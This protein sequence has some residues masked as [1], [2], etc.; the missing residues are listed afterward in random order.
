MGET[1]AAEDQ[2]R[3]SSEEEKDGEGSDVSLIVLFFHP[4]HV[5][6]GT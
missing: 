3:G 5:S 4:V 2:P 1:A 6:P